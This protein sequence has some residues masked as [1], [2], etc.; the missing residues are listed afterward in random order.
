MNEDDLQP[1]SLRNVITTGTERSWNRAMAAIII[2][3]WQAM[4]CR[5]KDSTTREP[6]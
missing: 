2:W 1:S 3:P 5:K 6:E 4:S